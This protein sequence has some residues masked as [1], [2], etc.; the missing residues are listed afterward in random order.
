[1]IFDIILQ[2]EKLIFFRYTK[3]NDLYEIL[4]R[5]GIEAEPVK[6]RSKGAG[7]GTIKGKWPAPEPESKLRSFEN[8][9]PEQEPEPLKF[10][11]LHQPWI[12]YFQ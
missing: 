11:R 9:G 4:V 6:F 8:L 2:A 10:S 7:I 12:Q 1:M 3:I 5:S